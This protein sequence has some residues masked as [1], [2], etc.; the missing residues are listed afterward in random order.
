LRE[1]FRRVE[2]RT[3]TVIFGKSGLGKTSL[4][5]AGLVPHLREKGY[6]PVTIRL[7]HAREDPPLVI[8]VIEQLR[9]AL[10]TAGSDELA[11]SISESIGFW[12][13]FHDPVNGMIMRDGSSVVRPVLIFDQF[14]EIYTL[15]EHRRPDAQAFREAL[16]ELVENRAPEALNERIPQD[17]DFA[18]RVQF[19]EAPCKVV[20]SL[21]EDFLS[22]LER[23]RS[24][25]PSLMD[26]RMELRPLTGPKA[27]MAV[28]RPGTL[29]P[30][31]P[32][33]VTSETATAIVRF[34]A[35][36]P[37]GIPLTEID[38]VPPLLS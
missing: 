28:F 19:E 24:V 26:N 35:G 36:A 37:A 7:G 30:R 15:S 8:Q 14:E 33:I 25:M 17:P 16:A 32:P 34:V 4:L 13:L 23:W 18:E 22:Q 29:R 11:G 5:Q 2:H 9:K 31:K 21:R 3:L 10:R 6:L 27:S 38:A 12:E 1:L 20:L